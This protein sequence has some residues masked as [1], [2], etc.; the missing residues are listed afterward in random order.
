MDEN[1]PAYGQPSAGYKRAT[2]LRP[3]GQ[4]GPFINRYPGPA[5]GRHIHC[6]WPGPSVGNKAR[7]ARA[8]PSARPWPWVRQM[9]RP[10]SGEPVVEDVWPSAACF[11]KGT[12]RGGAQ[13]MYRANSARAEG[14]DRP[15]APTTYLRSLSGM[16]RGVTHGMS[17]F[18][19]GVIRRGGMIGPGPTSRRITPGAQTGGSVTDA[20][21]LLFHVGTRGAPGRV[22]RRVPCP[23]GGYLHTAQELI[24]R[25][26]K[27]YGTRGA[28]GVLRARPTR[29][30]VVGRDR[31]AGKAGVSARS[32]LAAVQRRLQG[33]AWEAKDSA[34]GR[35]AGSRF[36]FR[37]PL[38]T[39]AT[40]AM[41]AAAGGTAAFG[42]ALLMLP[43]APRNPSV[44]DYSPPDMLIDS[45]V[46]E[47]EQ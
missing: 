18:L 15:S 43:A 44:P 23:G 41:K 25:D 31:T 40:A 36:G 34:T 37:R 30:R 17:V 1:R 9:R 28:G 26:G 47:I 46:N 24:G 32:P 13:D 11:S 29:N 8:S 33:G 7:P 38:R 45:A 21:F 12:V 3:R 39:P 6:R 10:P 16:R 4:V 35:P 2:G 19:I 27:T 42:R 22:A 14:P 20:T 5:S